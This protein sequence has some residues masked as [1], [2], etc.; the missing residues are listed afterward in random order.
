MERLGTVSNSMRPEWLVSDSTRP[1]SIRRRWSITREE[2]FYQYL[3]SRLWPIVAWDCKDTGSHSHSSLCL[4]RWGWI[5]GSQLIAASAQSD[6]LG[7]LFFPYIMEKRVLGGIGWGQIQLWK[8]TDRLG[9]FRE[10]MNKIEASISSRFAFYHS[11]P[12]SMGWKTP[13]S[14]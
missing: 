12:F 3:H 1:W 13:A 10:H 8:G 7:S 6:F 2:I 5:G 11:A 4:D 14:Y 9:R